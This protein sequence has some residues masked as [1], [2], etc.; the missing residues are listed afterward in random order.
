MYQYRGAVCH[1]ILQTLNGSADFMEIPADMNRLAV[2]P[3]G[4][5]KGIFCF[6]KMVIVENTAYAK[7]TDMRNRY[8]GVLRSDPK[9]IK[10]NE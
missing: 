6:N 10:H 1:N 7:K 3:I 5:K 2:I 9:M 4:T 8:V